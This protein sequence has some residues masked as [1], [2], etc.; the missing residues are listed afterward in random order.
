[1]SNRYIRQ[2]LEERM[3]ALGINTGEAKNKFIDAAICNAVKELE[4]G[5]KNNE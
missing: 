1:M 3:S 5:K 2:D 4:G